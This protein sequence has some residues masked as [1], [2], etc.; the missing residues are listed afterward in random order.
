MTIHC[1]KLTQRYHY[2]SKLEYVKFGLVDQFSLDAVSIYES[3]LVAAQ[4]AG[5]SIK[6]ILIC[7]PHN[8]LGRTYP[9]STLRAL[10]DLAS[11]FNVHLISD[12][13]YALSM[14][15]VA[16][17]EF[18]K[19]TSVLGL[20]TNRPDLVHVLYGM[21][22]VQQSSPHTKILA[23]LSI[24]IGFRMCRNAPRLSHLSQPPS[25]RSPATNNTFRR[26]FRIQHG[27][28]NSAALRHSLREIFPRHQHNKTRCSVCAYDSSS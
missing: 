4:S 6:A 26:T 24:N 19:F 9:A 3:A 22:K 20:E 17:R 7:N 27:S 10:L 16:G 15:P 23:W 8:P 25:T 11:R 28:R 5:K 2:R 1:Y 12:E 14:F 13:I 18:E 21:S